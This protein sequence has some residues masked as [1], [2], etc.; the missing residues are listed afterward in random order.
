M[1]SR[2]VKS[3]IFILSLTFILNQALPGKSQIRIGNDF[4]TNTVATIYKQGI[5]LINEKYRKIPDQSFDLSIIFVSLK[6]KTNSME[7]S[8]LTYDPNAI[9]ITLTDDSKLNISISKHH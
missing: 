5:S 2:F 6:I 7:L 9:K 1:I 4:F 3:L 8:P